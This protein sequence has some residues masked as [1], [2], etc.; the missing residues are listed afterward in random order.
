MIT[1]AKKSLLVAVITSLFTTTLPAMS[2]SWQERRLLKPTVT[3]RMAEDNGKIMI[4]DGL[5]EQ[6][7]SNAMDSEF[8]RIES[9]MFVRT[10]YTEPDGSEVEDEDCD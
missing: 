6:V 1:L 2:D 3:E 7:V 4:Y 9:M 10:K 5:H 8:S